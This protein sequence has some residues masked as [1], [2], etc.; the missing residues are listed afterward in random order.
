MRAGTTTGC[1]LWLPI[2]SGAGAM[3]F[4]REGRGPERGGAESDHHDPNRSGGIQRPGRRGLGREVGAAGRQRHWANR[5]Y[6]RP[7]LEAVAAV[8]PEYFR[9]LAPG[10]PAWTAA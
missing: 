7:R 3:S 9:A 5:D 2:S 8:G 4:S 10:P 6:A 1:R